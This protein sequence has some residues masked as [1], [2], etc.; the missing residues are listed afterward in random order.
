M[1]NGKLT[2]F[3]AWQDYGIN[4]AKRIIMFHYDMAPAY[5]SHEIGVEYIIRNLMWLD[6]E[7]RGDI[8]LWI[9]C[10]GG[11]VSEMWAGS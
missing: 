7:K 9:N 3:E 2:E 8:T 4:T 10:N 1:P 11:W 5:E 6:K